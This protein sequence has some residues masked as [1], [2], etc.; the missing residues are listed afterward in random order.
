MDD[1]LIDRIF[2]ELDIHS[3][4]LVALSKIVHTN[5]AIL[6]VVTKL[7]ICIISFLVVT[8]LGSLYKYLQEDSQKPV[9]QQDIIEF[10]NPNPI[11]YEV[12]RQ[13]S[14]V[15]SKGVKK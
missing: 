4:R 9:Q 7:I 10:E 11:V 15:Q 1:R 14:E 12:K 6:G 2:S 3:E 5:A 13:S 8:S